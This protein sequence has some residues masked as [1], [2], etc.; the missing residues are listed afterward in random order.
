M[1]ETTSSISV[2]QPFVR[3]LESL[4]D[5]RGGVGRF[6]FFRYGLSDFVLSDQSWMIFVGCREE[7]FPCNIYPGW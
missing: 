1:E 3:Q 2:L 4:L 6:N 7:V 5:V